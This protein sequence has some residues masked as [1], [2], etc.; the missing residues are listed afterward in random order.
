MPTGR[1]TVA[2]AILVFLLGVL[3][4]A[5]APG[6][7]PFGGPFDDGTVHVSAAD[8]HPLGT[9]SVAVADTPVER[10]FGL[11]NTEPLSPSEGML[12]VFPEEGQRT[13]VMRDMDYPLDIV[14]VGANGS[15]THVAHA[16]VESDGDLTPYSARAKW[17][18][19]VPAGWTT[20]HGVSVGDSVRIDLRGGPGSAQTSVQAK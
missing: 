18:L 19:E 6:I 9:V 20:D 2:V 14:F 17:V 8:G 7:P 11:S 3:V 10:Y 16:P 1:S 15:I 5:V 13:F 12:F 4:L